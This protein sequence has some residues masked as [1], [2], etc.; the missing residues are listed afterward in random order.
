M[1]KGAPNMTERV[2]LFDQEDNLGRNVKQAK[3]RYSQSHKMT[4][5]WGKGSGRD[6]VS[7]RLDD[8]RK[9]EGEGAWE[10]RGMAQVP[11]Y[12][13]GD[14]WH[15]ACMSVPTVLVTSFLFLPVLISIINTTKGRGQTIFI[16][17]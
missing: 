4:L 10:N 15:D 5:E 9:S 11:F 1:K 13:T 17:Q 8:R 16:I 3:D 2:M 6:V 7:G 12:N 14:L